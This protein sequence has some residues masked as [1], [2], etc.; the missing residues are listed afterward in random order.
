MT[1]NAEKDRQ[2]LEDLEGLLKGQEVKGLRDSDERSVLEAARKIASLKEKPSREFAESLKAQLVHQLAEQEKK[3]SRKLSF[4]SWDIAHMTMWQWTVAGLILV[5]I[6]A[7]IL[8]ATLLS[9]S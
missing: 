6:T 3:N 5:A 4:M 2:L 7:A 9:R 8:L 1:D